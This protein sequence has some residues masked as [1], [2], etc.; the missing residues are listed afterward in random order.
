MIKGP[1]LEYKECELAYNLFPSYAGCPLTKGYKMWS[2][3]PFQ[4]VPS[5]DSVR[6]NEKMIAS[7]VREG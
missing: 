6:E 7:V 5:I 2:V 4:A 1:I 3:N